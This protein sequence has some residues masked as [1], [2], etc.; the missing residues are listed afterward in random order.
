MLEVRLETGRKNQIRAHLSEAK[1]P[2]IGD[3]L[4]TQNGLHGSVVSLLIGIAGA[5]WGGLGVTTAAESAFARVWD[6]PRSSFY[7]ARSR[8]ASAVV[9]LKRGPKSDFTDEQLTARV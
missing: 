4:K 6:V 3:Q 8:A 5:L 2:V 7:A 1:H 9:A